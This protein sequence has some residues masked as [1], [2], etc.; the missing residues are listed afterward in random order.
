[1]SKRKI[2]GRAPSYFQTFCVWFFFSGLYVELTA[3]TVRFICRRFL[4]E[5]DPTLEDTYVKEAQVDG[6]PVRLHI[7]DTAGEVSQSSR[8]WMLRLGEIDTDEAW[9]PTWSTYVTR[10]RALGTA[11]TRGGRGFVPRL[12]ALSWIRRFLPLS[13]GIWKRTNIDWSAESLLS[14]PFG[15]HIAIRDQRDR[16]RF[17]PDIF[18]YYSSNFWHRSSFA[19]LSSS[20]GEKTGVR[21][22]IVEQVHAGHLYRELLQSV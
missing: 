7:L 9:E 1:M 13:R 17:V 11:Q 2:F 3:L 10:P 15:Q 16:H 12:L 18:F 14:S 22:C 6:R 5:Y 4:S 8:K 20:V 21:S 19:Q